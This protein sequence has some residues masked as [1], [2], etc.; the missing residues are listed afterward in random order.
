MILLSSIKPITYALALENGYTAA[1]LIDD[2]KITYQSYGQTY[3]PRNYDNRFHGKVTLRTALA[4]SYNIPAVKLVNAL[5][6]DNMVQ[7][8]KDMGLDNWVVA[9]GS[10]GL[11]VTLGGKEVR[12]LDL[13]NV[14][15]TFARQGV[16]RE[17]TPF[18]SI[19]DVYGFEVN[20]I[21]GNSEKEVLK[22]ETSYLISHILSDNSARTPTFGARSQLV[23][24]GQTVAVKTG[25]TNDIRDNLTVGY[26]PTYTVGVWVG[27]N[28][29]TPMNPRLASGLSGAST[30]WNSVFT[31]I[32]KDSEKEAFERPAGIFVKQDSECNNAVEVFDKNSRIP[33]N[34]CDVSDKDKDKDKDK[35][36][37]D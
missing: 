33:K 6:V 21:N 20:N 13:A 12:L 8:G 26:T 19:T 27:N 1:T 9:D 34:L 18:V 2:S 11:A 16:Y 5:G 10:Y 15:A 17:T 35:E 23:I 14:Y 3:T 7:L 30:I 28:D 29:N 25:T 36:K 37:D 24:P 22:P 32:L 31:E 4:N